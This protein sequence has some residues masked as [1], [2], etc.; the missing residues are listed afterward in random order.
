MCYITPQKLAA[1]ALLVLAGIVALGCDRPVARDPEI[2]PDVLIL[3]PIGDVDDR[4]SSPGELDLMKKVFVPGSEPSE[5]DLQRYPAYRYEGKQ[6]SQSG[7]SATV[8]V[9]LTDAKTGSPAGE[10]QWSLTK[11]NGTWRIKDAPLPNPASSAP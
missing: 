6:I 9:V 11:V 5:K 10:V 3:R 1:G 7:D 2:P 8:T 4:S